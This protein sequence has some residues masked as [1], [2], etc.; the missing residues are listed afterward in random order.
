MFVYHFTH[1]LTGFF[2]IAALAVVL[3]TVV[4][5]DVL[6]GA[7]RKRV[8]ARA[9]DSVAPG[10]PASVPVASATPSHV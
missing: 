8:D 4:L 2:G 6:R 3:A 1:A 5:T 9:A 10:T 7:R